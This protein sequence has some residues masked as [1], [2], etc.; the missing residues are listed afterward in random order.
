[1]LNS[2]QTK[3]VA[4]MRDFLSA[5]DKPFFL[6]AGAAGTGKTFCISSLAKVSKLRFAFTAP[7]NKATKVLREAVT[8]ETFKPLCKTIYSLLGLQ[9]MP[10]GGV[11]EL[12]EPDDPV[13][14]T[15]FDVVV[16]DEASMVS[17]VLWKHIQDAAQ[18]H[19]LKF[20]LMG[21]DAQLP[22]VG[23]KESKIWGLGAGAVLEEQ[24]RSDSSIVEFA[25][26]VRLAQKSF[27][28]RVEMKS[29]GDVE[30]LNK[31][32]LT[33]RIRILADSGELANGGAK[34]IAWRNVTVDNLNIQVRAHLFNSKDMWLVG[35]RVILTEPATNL[36]P[37]ATVKILANTDDEGIVTGI[38]RGFHPDFADIPVFFINVTLDDNRLVT[39]TVPA[40]PSEVTARANTLAERAKLTRSLWPK[41]WEFKESFH[42]LRHAYAITSH[43]SQGSSYETAVVIV[44]DILLNRDRLEAF[45]SLY[46]A[47]SR[48]KHK[49]YLA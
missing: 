30:V 25:T 46:V 35:D 13:D 22:P 32:A 3:A 21:D 34:I 48:P 8:S 7:T 40:N 12:K 29:E 14:L 23:E 1:M 2:D 45:K 24:M 37:D 19:K 26:R 41:F 43:R 20:I 10:N 11:K 15:R 4:A 42:S 27:L 5:P 16:V 17:E 49:L 31:A 18:L 33:E 36:A 39:L 47:T 44:S 38:L 9:L 6:L 28:P